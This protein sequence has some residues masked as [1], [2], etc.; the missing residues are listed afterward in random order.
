MALQ[1][2]PR[3]DDLAIL[4]DSNAAVQRLL[5]FRSHNFRPAEHKIKDYDILHDILLE[6]KLRSDTSSRTFFVEV[7]GHSGDPFHEE[8]DRLAVEGADT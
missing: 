7:H 6:L 4:I 3:A 8:A 5:W 1:G 2:S